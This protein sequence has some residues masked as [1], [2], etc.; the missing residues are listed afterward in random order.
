[1]KALDM[2][3]SNDISVNLIGFVGLF[4]RFVKPVDER[5]HLLKQTHKNKKS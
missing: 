2:I 1:M 4:L 5:L 3:H